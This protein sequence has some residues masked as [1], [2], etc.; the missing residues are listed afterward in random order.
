MD[1][2]E[3]RKEFLRAFKFLLFSISAGAIQAGSIALLE[4]L[5]PLRSFICYLIGLILSV[6][7]NFTLNRKFTF[8]SANNVPVAML[9]VALYYLVFTPISV[10]GVKELTET[11]MWHPVFADGLAMVI[12]LVTEFLYQ[13]FFVF[14]STL[15]TNE[16]A[17]R[18]REA[19]G[20]K[21]D[22]REDA[23]TEKSE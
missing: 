8:K 16:L 9:K 21:A 15:D 6:L 12:N 13:R 10:Y 20:G 3:K 19:A 1:K 22:G 23:A 14:G 4:W 2:S 7:W 11:A 17:R 18:E 5:T